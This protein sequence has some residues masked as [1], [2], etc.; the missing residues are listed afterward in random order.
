MK[1]I[2]CLLVGA[3]SAS[4]AAAE[5]PTPSSIQRFIAVDNVC[6][7]PSLTVLPDG[8][9]NATLFGKPSHGQMEGAVECWNSADGQFWEKR[10]IPAPNEAHTNRMNHAA[11][12]AKNGDLIVLCSGWTDVKQPQ[13]P[14]Q[15]AFRDDI[16]PL[17]VC[18]SSDGGK[19]WSQI[20]AFPAPD[21]GWTNYIPFGDIKQGDDGALHVSCYGGEFTDPTKSTKTK[22]YRSWHFRSDDDGK[23]WQRTGT[24]HP[25]GNET[26][27]LHLGGKRW[28]AAAR[29]TGMDIFISEDD[30]VSWGEPNRVTHKN[31][32]N[33]HLLRLKDGRILLSHGSR[34]KEQFGVLAKFTSDEG[35][36]WSAPVRIAKTLESDCGYPSTVQ[37]ADGKLVTAWYSK[38]SENHQRYHMGV[39]I[40]EAP[41]P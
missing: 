23:T 11:G 4:L 24:I 29:E 10:G 14:K 33:G 2:H 34:V 39:A 15:A 27:I 7:W 40:W 26:T 36:T 5:E 41:Q 35:E 38:T 21:E 37:R 19:T 22:G 8:S 3:L 17:W 13:R 20:K 9:I 1:L 31:E 12:I 18:R 16:L 30:G 32:I 25:T 6:A 28:M